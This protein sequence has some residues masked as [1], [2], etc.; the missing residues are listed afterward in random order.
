[1]RTIYVRWLGA[2]GGSGRSRRSLQEMLSYEAQAPRVRAAEYLHVKG[3]C[4][5]TAVPT[6][7][8][9]G[10]VFGSESVTKKFPKDIHSYVDIKGTGLRIDS[11]HY[12]YTGHTEAWI[13]VGA[14]PIAIIIKDA[15]HLKAAVARQLIDF[16]RATPSIK[17]IY[18]RKRRTRRRWLGECTLTNL[19]DWFMAHYATAGRQM[20]TKIN[21]LRDHLRKR[22]WPR[23]R[24][25]RRRANMHP[26]RRSLHL[27][28]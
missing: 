27:K 15:Y 1:M 16:I 8:G 22:R 6:R 26:R 17:A 23:L 9:I 12:N 7:A 20:A 19:Y 21:K 2:Y 3:T 18:N 14:S 5:Y 11:V 4:V 25:S 10:L 28:C 24:H 13:A